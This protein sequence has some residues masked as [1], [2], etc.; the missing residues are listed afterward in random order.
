[1]ILRY[2]QI[3]GK[4][5]FSFFFVLHNL[6]LLVSLEL[7][8]QFSWDYLLNVALKYMIQLSRKLDI[9]ICMTSG[10]FCLIA[11]YLAHTKPI[12]YIIQFKLT[13]KPKHTDT[14]ASFV[15]NEY[16]H[17]LQISNKAVTWSKLKVLF[18]LQFNLRWNSTDINNIVPQ[19]FKFK[20][21]FLSHKVVSQDML[22]FWAWHTFFFFFFFAC[23]YI[24]WK[25]ISANL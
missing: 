1:M 21:P 12:L 18:Y 8:D 13:E 24:S 9:G 4:I 16:E 5:S 3:K 14:S 6:H 10:S 2:N 17:A 23:E 11:S 20:R 22:C 19:K 15:F 25:K 7:I